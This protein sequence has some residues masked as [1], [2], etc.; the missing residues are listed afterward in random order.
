VRAAACKWELREQRN[1]IMKIRPE[2][3]I[4]SPW[5]KWQPPSPDAYTEIAVHDDDSPE[6]MPRF[7]GGFRQRARGSELIIE[8]Q[9]PWLCL[10]AMQSDFQL[11]A[12]RVQPQ[13]NS[14]ACDQR[15]VRLEPKMMG[16][17]VCLAQRSGDVV[18]KEQIVQEVWRD[19]FVTDDVLVR[20][21]SGLRKVFGDD[22]VKPA[23]IETIPKR[24]YRLL[25]PVV[26][27]ASSPRLHG[28]SP[29]EFADSIAVLPFENAGPDPE[30]EYLSDG[31]AET[32]INCLSR[33]QNLRVVPRTT[34]FQCKRKSLNP[35]EVGHELGV[36]LVLTGHVRQQR[37]RVVV[38][39][40]LIDAPR[41][42]QLWGQTYDRKVDDIFWI[43]NQIATEVPNYLRMRLTDVEKRQL[44][45]RPTESR[46]A[47][48]L[49]LKALFFA[50]KYSP[51]GFAKGLDYCRQAIEAD[52][53]FADAYAALSYLYGL[54]GA[55]DVM[56]AR[57]VFP[58]ARA[59]AVRA[60]EIDDGS[61]DSHAGL[62]FVLMLHDWDWQSAEAEFLRAIELGPHMP[63]AHYAYSIWLLAQ[64][65]PEEAVAEAK[66]ALELDPLSLPKN[67]HLG[68]VHFLGREYDA[69]IDQ[70]R[71][72]TELDAS[73]GM[74]HHILA[75]VHAVKGMRA[76]ALAEAMRAHPLSDEIYSRVTFARINALTGQ[77][78]EARE[79]LTRLEHVEKA[80]KP[81]SCRAA[82]CA[83]IH[84]LL[85]EPDQAFEWLDRAYEEREAALIYL[86]YFPDFESLHKDARFA[87][88]LRRIGLPS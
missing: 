21:V 2:E 59:A 58:R 64:D 79:V 18:S 50:N 32:I 26:P 77:P 87:D 82:W 44:A 76:D 34:T 62:G 51:E 57:E 85:G 30:M 28:V 4:E 31:I 61:S 35:A 42:S 66:R 84:A 41:H 52:P 39:T 17:L 8:R 73:F 5:G 16:V 29:S 78:D 3:F 54:L 80:T 48:H 86:R 88:L 9:M 19:T 23:V 49:Y 67:C 12:W 81:A 47:Y 38:G 1:T 63:R 7:E 46:E 74:A 43:Q 83:M 72:T 25:L 45:R 69:A 10:C 13:L 56:P 22:A 36:R 37:E 6:E 33:L 27:I 55:F 70:L 53:L 20:C 60:L 11:G 68:V 71:R 75:L 24:G 40:E 65:R 15:T 14:L